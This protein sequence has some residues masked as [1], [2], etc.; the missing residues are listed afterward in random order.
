MCVASP[1]DC[2]IHRAKIGFP[3][4]Y[5]TF[6]AHHNTKPLAGVTEHPGA[7]LRECQLSRES[8]LTRF[9]SQWVSALTRFLCCRVGSHEAR[10]SGSVSSRG[11]SALRQLQLFGHL[12]VGVS[13]WWA[14]APWSDFWSALGERQPSAQPSASATPGLPSVSASSPFTPFVSTSVLVNVSN[15]TEPDSKIGQFITRSK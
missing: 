7:P 3:S 9:M 2:K 12:L 14:S 6:S 11:V 1:L 15:S 13:R 4:H 10:L 8:S 5:Y